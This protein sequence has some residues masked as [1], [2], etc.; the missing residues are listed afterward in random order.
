MKPGKLESA[1]SRQP[2]AWASLGG[3]VVS[4]VALAWLAAEIASPRGARL[5]GVTLRDLALLAS[6]SLAVGAAALVLLLA[7]AFLEKLVPGKTLRDVFR[8]APWFVAAVVPVW[9]LFDGAWVRQQAWR[10]PAR[11]AAVLLLGV[12][13]VLWSAL[14]RR[15]RHRRSLAALF[16]VAGVVVAVLDQAFLVSLYAPLHVFW[17]LVMMAATASAAV[18]LRI[19]FSRW[20]GTGVVVVSAM[21]AV[22]VAA[23]R[24]PGE[25][26]ADRDLLLRRSSFSR[27]LLVL[28]PR[29]NRRII[30]SREIDPSILVTRDYPH[31]DLLDRFFPDRRRFNVVLI[32]VDTLRADYCG[33][34]GSRRG[35]TPRMDE[36]SRQCFIFE[37]AYAAYPSTMFS[38]TS[39]LTGFYPSATAKESRKSTREDAPLQLRMKEQG[40]R[41]FAETT[42]P[43]V[44]SRDLDSLTIGWTEA[45]NPRPGEPRRERQ[46]DRVVDRALK[47]LGS[48]DGS[49]PWMFWLHLFDPHAFYSRHPEF[50]YGTETR[51]LY[52]GEIAF[53]DSHL[54]RFLSALAARSDWER[55]VVILHADHGQEFFERGG[56]GH[57]STLYEEQVHVPLIIRL[58]GREPH[59]ISTPVSLVDFAPTLTHLLDL[60]DPLPRNGRSRLGLMLGDE[61]PDRERELPV[62]FQLHDGS[63]GQGELDGMRWRSFKIIENLLQKVVEV[64][65][66]EA[67]PAEKHNLAVKDPDLLQRLIPWLRAEQT[68]ASR[69]ALLDGVS[70][71]GVSVAE[72]DDWIR[73]GYKFKAFAAMTEALQRGDVSVED[74]APIIELLGYAD[75][76]EARPFLIEASKSWTGAPLRGALRALAFLD[77]DGP[78]R[79][80]EER[81]RSDDSQ[82][83]LLARKLLALRGEGP[84]V[85]TDLRESGGEDLVLDVLAHRDEDAVRFARAVVS[86]GRG[87]EFDQGLALRFLRALDDPWLMPACYARGVF[88][89]WVSSLTR[90][91]AMDALLSAPWR[92]SYPLLRW[93]IYKGRDPLRSIVERKIAPTGV[94]LDMSLLRHVCKTSEMLLNESGENPDVERRA[95]SVISLLEASRRAGIHDWGLILEYFNAGLSGGLSPERVLT[96]LEGYRTHLEG[97]E[98]EVPPF[99]DRWIRLVRSRT[100]GRTPHPRVT[101]VQWDPAPR[102]GLWRGL[103]KLELAPDGGGMF[104][105]AYGMGGGV[106]Y[107]F[108]DSNDRPLGKPNAAWLPWD[109][110]LPGESR[111]LLLSF[112]VP[113]GGRAPHRLH[114]IPLERHVPMGSPTTVVLDP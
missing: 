81:S 47:R 79:A 39:F 110:L 16:L 41:T 24:L 68:A 103:V 42:F 78:K 30:G 45:N 72:L 4:I 25:S 77:G 74:L 11:W 32:T 75:V 17:L 89:P 21:A 88:S 93:L 65:D 98:A 85:V 48:I 69:V 71:R 100:G 82:A 2:P 54:G 96:D 73:R 49:T 10:T 87:S 92:L 97:F 86:T 90:N 36:F 59:R 7:G 107:A 109:G 18:L 57:G 8:A 26:I 111:Y 64:Y 83:A 20:V 95:R 63:F 44:V 91:R 102:E 22:A 13:G 101:L 1:G 31:Q 40:W 29:R 76:D 55:T 61:W 84:A 80:L 70:R 113:P 19:P 56:E 34:L 6:V 5:E 52:A 105:L 66:L 50:D 14:M 3:S 94:G 12:A 38:V 114:F 60:D 27:K 106:G 108:T 28:L 15:V 43:E 33:F 62:F 23:G 9:G 67:D 37:N 46:G 112:E 51:D 53:A 58:P 35:L 99:L 104:P